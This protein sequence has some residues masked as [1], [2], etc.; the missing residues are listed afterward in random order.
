MGSP[1]SPVVANL[2][3]EVFEERAL[4]SAVLRPRLWLRYVDDT[5]VLWPHS[6]DELDTF[7]DHLNSQHPAI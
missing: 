3:M 2:F 1:L 7:Q 5:F 4:V 6:T